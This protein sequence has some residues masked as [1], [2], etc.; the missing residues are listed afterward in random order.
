MRCVGFWLSAMADEAMMGRCL[1][2][3]SEMGA[4]SEQTNK[5]WFYDKAS[6]RPPAQLGTR[7]W[8]RRFVHMICR[9]R[10]LGYH[11]VGRVDFEKHANGDTQNRF[12]ASF[13]DWSAN[14]GIVDRLNGL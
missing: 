4:Q 13:Q 3:L 11:G 7:T 14:V 12:S 10:S 9:N 2:H 1:V 5:M 8:L 6:P